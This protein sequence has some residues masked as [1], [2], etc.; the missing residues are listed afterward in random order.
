MA[1]AAWQGAAARS[2]AALD[3]LRIAGIYGP[4]GRNLLGQL[5]AGTARA[6][7]KPGQVFN[8]IHRDDIAG[9]MLAVM[10][11]PDGQRLTNLSDGAACPASEVL[12]GVA[13]MLDLPPPPQ[14]A[15]ADA[16][17]PPAPPGSMPRTA[18]CGTTGCWPCRASACN[19]PTGGRA[20]AR[21]LPG[22]GHPARPVRRGTKGKGRPGFPWAAF[23]FLLAE[24]RQGPGDH[25]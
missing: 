5:R 4:E 2:G 23:R 3:I 7:L 6:I 14:V 20:I 21:S 8:H 24:V 19:I 9:A 12:L 1:E 13:E 25:P 15:F 16:G 11:L 22:S 17:L 10:A 18:G